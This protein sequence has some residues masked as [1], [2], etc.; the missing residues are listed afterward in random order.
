LG[1]AEKGWIKKRGEVNA[2]EKGKD[3]EKNM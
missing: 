1:R 3:D 2:K